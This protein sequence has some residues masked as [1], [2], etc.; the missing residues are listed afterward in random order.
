MAYRGETLDLT[1]SSDDEQPPKAALP[2]ARSQSDRFAQ[3]PP[4]RFVPRIQDSDD[5]E[6]D[7]PVAPARRQASQPKP[8]RA[9]AHILDS[10]DE[11]EDEGQSASPPARARLVPESD[12]DD[13]TEPDTESDGEGEDLGTADTSRDED[14]PVEEGNSHDSFID[15]SAS[16][17]A[18]FVSAASD[19]Q[20]ERRPTPPAPRERAQ[21]NR[22]PPP[23]RPSKP[24]HELSDAQ[25][26]EQ[27]GFVLQKPG[28]AFPLKPKPGQS[29]HSQPFRPLANTLGGGAPPRFPSSSSTAPNALFNTSS[30]ARKPS[31]GFATSTSAVGIGAGSNARPAVSQ[32]SAKERALEQMRFEQKKL[33]VPIEVPKNPPGGSGS[34]RTGLE[35]IDDERALQKAMQG[36]QVGDN[37]SGEDQEAA[38]KELVSSTTDMEGVDMTDTAIDGLKV[39]L[40]AHQVQGVQW[41]R[42]RE[43]GKKRGGILADDMGLGKTIQ[44]LALILANPSDRKA[45]RSKTTLVVCPVALMEQW[46]SEIQTKSDG[47][48]RVLIHHGPGRAT[49]ARKLQKY[50]VVIT[51]YQTCSSE[52]VD[53]KPSTKKSK[54]KKKADEDSGDELDRLLGRK[55]GR[56]ECGPLFDDEYMFYRVILDEAHQIKGRTTKMHKSCCALDTHYRWC[57]T[58]TPV[59]NTVMDLYSL[60]EFLGK[61]VNPLHNYS[62]FKAK[63][64]DPLKNNKRQKIAFARLSIV[65]KA[66][67]LRRTKTMEVNGKPLL[68]LPDRE[69]IE[70]KGP[71]LDDE[72][73]KFYKAVEEAMALQMNAYIK[74]GTVMQNYTEVLIKL[75]RMRQACNHPALI[76]GNA[77]VDSDALELTPDKEGG[78]SRSA[79]KSDDL[80]G[81]LDSMSLG[82]SAA[83]ASC[84][85]CSSPVTDADSIYCTSCAREMAKYSSLSFST[86]IRQTLRLLSDIKQESAAERDRVEMENKRRRQATPDSDD[87]DVGDVEGQELLEYRPKKTIIFSQFTTMFD[88]LEPF[89]KKGGYRYTRF[90]G[91]LNQRQ[92]EEAL[93]KIRTDP[94]CTVILVSLKCGAVGLNLTVCSRVLLLD[95]WWNPAIEQQAFDR[96]HRFG[97]KDDVKIYKLMIEGTVEERILK[98]QETKAQLAKASLEG[99]GDLGKAN[100]LNLQDILYLFRGDGSGGRASSRL[101]EDLDE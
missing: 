25:Q 76:T 81:L 16:A 67:M 38:L 97:Q 96:A 64:G 12:E 41:L 11:D 98:M 28:N 83:A 56:S 69:I 5:D 74:S 66:V 79:S 40:L 3:Q 73:L 8:N 57:L 1:L 65:L 49:D 37:L 72:E 54:S 47:R 85:M 29:A 101:N 9:R 53:P 45:C 22:P 10:E 21:E 7:S 18:S 13:G 48:L 33:G 93:N 63:I 14:E 89:L 86:K 17:D 92:K 80:A 34:G 94:K 61:I 77:S 46:K 55:N 88:L 23:P 26:L 35:G 100:K 32:A 75:L 90:D 95:L 15:D 43:K 4:R 58:G 68:Q 19:Y 51:S 30:A 20:A 99:G 78:V 24:Q 84:A 59:Q 27:Y 62:E 31:G 91:K 70:V 60:F 6:N 87:E 39:T 2:S 52:W 44:L 50:D 36:L 42:D 82:S 71:F